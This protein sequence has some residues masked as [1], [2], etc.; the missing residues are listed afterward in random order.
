MT[1][2][3]R[4]VAHHYLLAVQRND[5]AAL[6]LH[7]DLSATFPNA[8]LHDAQ[9]Y[10]AA[11]GPFLQSVQAIRLRQIIAEGEHAV[12]LLDI[13]TARGTL[14]FAEHL[15]IVDGLIVHVRGYYDPR[16]LL[17]A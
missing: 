11:L 14:E 15:H 2:D 17:S 16:P 10:R 6:P 5:P 7:P 4:Q 9:A 13:D 1:D 3:I 12:L 8:T